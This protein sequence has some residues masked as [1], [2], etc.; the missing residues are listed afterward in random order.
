LKNRF[1]YTQED[2][3]FMNSLNSAILEKSPKK[4]KVILWFWIIT[5]FLF[6]AWAYFSEVDEIVRGEGKVIS[7][8]ENKMIQN[9]EGGILD[10]IFVKEGDIVKKGDILLRIDNQKSVAD[11]EATK[12]KSLELSAKLKRLR[13][14]IDGT[15][16]FVDENA[17]DEF[18]HYEQLE[19]NLFELDRNRLNSEIAALEEQLK[20]KTND[21]NST[22]SS[23]NY[24]NS[25]Y[26]LVSQELKIA[27]PLVVKKLKPQSELLRIKRDANNI[28]MQ[29][30]EAR[31]SIPKIESLIEE[32]KNKISESKENF[33]KLAQEQLNESSAELERINASINNLKDKVFRTNVYSPNDGIIQK[34][35]FNTIG[36]V[37]K[38]GDNLVEI[39]PTGENLLIQ[40]KIKP[41]DIAFIHYDQKAQVKFTAYDY[42]IYG[43]L[44]GRVV[45]I[46]P[47]TEM[48][49]V[50]KESFYNINVQTQNNHLKKGKQKLP[51]IPGMVVHVDILTGKKTV[52]DYIMKPILRAK[53]YT[54]TER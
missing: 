30:A 14:E 8:D 50:K 20:Q 36:G 4:L 18:K 7:F 44:E 12:L 41:A 51:I 25:E 52:F 40:T 29:L 43:G 38:P 28:Q 16:F 53:Q 27:T 9:L 45:K 13:S 3:E 6:I 24:L 32:T 15:D 5:I 31:I 11:Y 39:V 48:D 19:L 42:A 21:L 22:K 33:K 37:I 2:Y 34:V 23:I 47:D 17:P 49:D 35:F 26:Y 1:N 54:F 46:S 10:E